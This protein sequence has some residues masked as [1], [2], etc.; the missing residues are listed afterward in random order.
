MQLNYAGWD[1]AGQVYADLPCL[2]PFAIPRGTIPHPNVIKIRREYSLHQNNISISYCLIRW[3]VVF[4]LLKC[5]TF[6][7]LSFKHCII[8]VKKTDNAFHIP[9]HTQM[10]DKIRALVCISINFI[11]P[12]RGTCWKNL[13]VFIG[14]DVQH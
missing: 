2:T 13:N 9:S 4:M 6:W 5:C 1:R 3:L 8:E 14:D 12:W 11:C 7:S 10:V